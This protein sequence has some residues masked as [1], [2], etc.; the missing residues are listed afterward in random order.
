M[1]VE[2]LISVLILPHKVALP[3]HTQTGVNTVIAGNWV[4]SVAN[5]IN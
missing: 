3:T 2:K 4:I 5:S 1:A